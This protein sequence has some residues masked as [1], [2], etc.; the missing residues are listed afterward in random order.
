M[1]QVLTVKVWIWLH[2]FNSSYTQKKIL[3]QIKYKNSPRFYNI[4]SISIVYKVTIG[5]I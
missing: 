5:K 4:L 1:L 3:Y 2:F